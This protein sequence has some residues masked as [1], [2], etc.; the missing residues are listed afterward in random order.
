M[1]VFAGAEAKIEWGRDSR[2]Q[3]RD[4]EGVE[5]VGNGNGVFPCSFD[6]GQKVLNRGGLPVVRNC[7]VGNFILVDSESDN[8]VPTSDSKLIF[9]DIISLFCDFM[10]VVANVFGVL[11]V[12]I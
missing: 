1:H 11:Y 7:Q 3:G 12:K 5:G 9:T 2:R 4:A 10:S 6:I 8:L